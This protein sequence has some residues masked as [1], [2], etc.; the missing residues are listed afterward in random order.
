[1]VGWA[2][3]RPASDRPEYSG[4]AE[5]AVY[6]GD[7]FRGHGVGKALIHRQVTAADRA[8]LWTLQISIFPQN[9]A[10][11]AVHQSAGF[12]TLGVP[13]TPRPPQHPR[14]LAR[15]RAVTAPPAESPP[16]AR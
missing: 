9:R 2:A 5:T 12:R 8:G 4:V 15:R 13:P 14:R 10:G 3:A 11:I 1:V 7:G 16:P 6:V